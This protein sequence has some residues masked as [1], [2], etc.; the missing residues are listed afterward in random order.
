MPVRT[1]VLTALV[2]AVCNLVAPAMCGGCGAPAR[3]L[4]DECALE[5]EA[6]PRLRTVSCAGGVDLP[7]VSAAPYDG[8]TRAV[9][10]AFKE[11]GRRGLARPLGFA[12]SHA[13]LVHDHVLTLTPSQPPAPP[14]QARGYV[15]R[16]PG[17][18]DEPV[19]L[20][21]VPSSPA[22]VRRRGYDPVRRLAAMTVRALADR[23]VPTRMCPAL[24]LADSVSDQAGLSAAARQANLAGAHAVVRR[25][26]GHVEGRHVLIVDDVVTTGA[27]IA[28]ATRAL[29][30]GGAQPAGA[31]TVGGTVLRSPLRSHRSGLHVQHG[32]D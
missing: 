11:R 32:C 16:E 26:A 3:P 17:H 25:L 31:L 10:L 28:E 12:M 7:V 29:R 30:A 18:A 21:P 22:A 8:V 6:G 13:A 2:A 24:R 9:V 27:T 23:G 15:L 19:L 5:L 1:E 20:V 4:C 14:T